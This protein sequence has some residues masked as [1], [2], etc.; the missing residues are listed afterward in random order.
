[1]MRFNIILLGLLFAA[2]GAA[3]RAG[4]IPRLPIPQNHNPPGHALLDLAHLHLFHLF[5][6]ADANRARPGEATGDH[7]SDWSQQS[8]LPDLSM[9][10]LHPEFGQDDSPFSGLSASEMPDQLGSSAWKDLENKSHSAK[11]M[12]IWPTGK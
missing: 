9:G 12:F 6:Q 10:P 1:M 5:H 3:G 2:T 4:S 11:L 8:Q 7:P